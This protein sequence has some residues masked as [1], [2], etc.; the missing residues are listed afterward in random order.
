[1][2]PVRYPRG[3]DKGVSAASVD[4]ETLTERVG[5]T[6]GPAHAARASVAQIFQAADVERVGVGAAAGAGV[7]VGGESSDAPPLMLRL[8]STFVVED[9]D[10]MPPVGALLCSDVSVANGGAAEGFAQSCWC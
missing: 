5:P 2:C 9:V 10:S 3:A 8:R 4:N 7:A 1:M 6:L